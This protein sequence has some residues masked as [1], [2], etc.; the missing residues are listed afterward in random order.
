MFC[1]WWC[2]GSG[3]A[4]AENWPELWHS[5]TE[6]PSLRASPDSPDINSIHIQQCRMSPSYVCHKT[7]SNCQ[8][9]ERTVIL[10]HNRLN[11]FL[12]AK[13]NATKNPDPKL[14]RAN[15]SSNPSLAILHCVSGSI[16][17]I[18]SVSP[19]SVEGEVTIIQGASQAK[20]TAEGWPAQEI[21]APTL[22]LL[23]TL[24]PQHWTYVRNANIKYIKARP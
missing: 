11:T 10:D 3:V 17:E 18:C 6:A 9:H 24:K 7:S 8:Q 12:P 15:H 4:G 13:W 22:L 21:F 19:L 20:L 16:L 5:V 14:P 2:S 1:Q 23:C